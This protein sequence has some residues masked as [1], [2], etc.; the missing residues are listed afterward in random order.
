[1]THVLT[2]RC[3]TWNQDLYRKIYLGINRLVV[4]LQKFIKELSRIHN[5]SCNCGPRQA[6]RLGIMEVWIPALSANQ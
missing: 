6:T 2:G 3:V 1:M 5:I 4:C